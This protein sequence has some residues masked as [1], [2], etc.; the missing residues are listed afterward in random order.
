[1]KVNVERDVEGRGQGRMDASLPDV[2]LSLS[3]SL[4]PGCSSEEVTAGG[5]KKARPRQARPTRLTR[6]Q[7][8]NTAERQE[9]R[10]RVGA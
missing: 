3:L 6:R 8:T 7:I 9:T 5:V 4:L 2:S 1:M 10:T